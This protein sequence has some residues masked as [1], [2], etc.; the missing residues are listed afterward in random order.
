MK[1][2]EKLSREAL[3]NL[4]ESRDNYLTE[5]LLAKKLA[6]KQLPPKPGAWGRKYTGL[7][8]MN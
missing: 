7:L 5:E 1:K 6:M 8:E 3:A 2:K 4:K